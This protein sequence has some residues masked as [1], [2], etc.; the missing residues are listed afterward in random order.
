[1]RTR[2]TALGGVLIAVALIGGSLAWESPRVPAAADGDKDAI[3]KSSADFQAAYEKRDAKALANFWTENGEYEDDNGVVLRGRAD[4]E[5]AY[6][7]FFKDQPPGKIE[8]RMES[9]RFPSP[10]CAI[11]EGFL[12]QDRGG[13][14]LPSSTL[15]RAF[16]VKDNGQ[17]KIAASREWGAGQDRLN[18]L[19]WLIGT[20]KGSANKAEMSLAVER[21][22]KQSCIVAKTMV[23][24]DGKDQST[25]TMRIAFDS[26]RGQLRSWHF[27]AEGGHG[28][29]LWIRDGNN[30]VL[31]AIGVTGDGADTESVNIIGRIGP[32]EITWRSIDRVINGQP[33][34]D[35]VPVKLTRVTK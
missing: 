11:E 4:I 34:P 9:L 27:D 35:T 22:D 13:K 6:A 20:W 16:H 19:E 15:Y 26:Q 3:Q 12:Q 21:D 18:D 30:W 17:W 23:K 10:N 32:N 29:S 8:V 33:L 14:E 7:D 25:G 24:A 31:D 28:Q 5:K 1:M 2:I